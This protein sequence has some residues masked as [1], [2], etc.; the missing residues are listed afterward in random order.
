MAAFS[1]EF[2]SENDFKAVLATFRCYEYGYLLLKNTIFV[3]DNM[4]KMH[5]YVK[6]QTEKSK[7][8]E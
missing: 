5:L 4:K 8:V 6:N 2:L 7:V 3:L 1:E